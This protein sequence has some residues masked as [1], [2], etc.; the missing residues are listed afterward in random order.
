MRNCHNCGSDISNKALTARWCSIKCKTAHRKGIGPVSHHDCRICGITFPIGPGQANKWL[1]SD[2]CRRASNAKSVREFHIRRPEAEA[3][4]RLRSK[5]KRLP[6]GNLVRFYRNNPDAPKCCQSCGEDRVLDVAH[7][8]G[9]E[10]LGAGRRSYNCKWPSIVWVL[11]P[12]C[13]M[14]LDRMNYPPDELG[15]K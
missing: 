5:E 1:C 12:T 9:H 6:D 15:L 8:P 11:C 4:F 13:H 3:L 14:L 2:N 10:R 7:R